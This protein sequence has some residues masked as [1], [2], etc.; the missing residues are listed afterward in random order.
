[1]KKHWVYITRKPRLTARKALVVALCAVI[2]AAP[3]YASASE[4]K[5]SGGY[6]HQE[7]EYDVY[8][9]GIHAVRANM[10]MDFTQKGRYIMGFGAE[11][12]GFLGSIV[13]WSGTFET[14]GWSLSGS[15]H[16]RI[17]EKHISTAM[18]RDEEEVKTYSYDKEKGFLDLTTEY[19]GKK[20]RTET[21]DEELT[22]GT[23]D[24]I[25]ATLMV[26]E[27]VSDGK[28][29]EGNREIFDG[30]RRFKLI[31]HHKGYVMLEKTRYNAYE[32]PAVECVVEVEPVSG[33]WYK[34]PRGWLSI[35][36]QGRS[37]GTMPTVWMAQV[38]ENAVVV[39]V[40]VRVKTTYGTMFM[41]MT[42]YKSG[43]TLLS[44]KE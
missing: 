10:I 38:V 22:K 2:G 35:Q 18:W 33:A 37:L 9:G 26:M 39:P 36:E 24:I 4:D 43:D 16:I 25:S 28:P 13:P 30:K 20:P 42:K 27:Q 32:G 5:L 17:P 1:M 31:F 29:C 21:P 7:V 41:H 44:I 6:N 8:A 12:R 15:P 19:V 14:R 23:T 34:K 11:T 3:S 40:R